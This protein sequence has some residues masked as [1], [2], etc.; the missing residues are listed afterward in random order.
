MR[1]KY[2]LSFSVLKRYLCFDLMSTQPQEQPGHPVLSFRVSQMVIVEV[3]PG[4]V[5]EE[6]ERDEREDVADDAQ[7]AADKEHDATHPE[8]EPVVEEHD[9]TE[10]HLKA[11]T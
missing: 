1:S 4:L 3:I 9:F 2:K 10:I 7:H 5:L 8:F 11:C 6:D